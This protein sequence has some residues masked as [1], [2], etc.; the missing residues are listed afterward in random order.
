MLLK[1]FLKKKEKNILKKNKMKIE[2]YSVPEDE[3]GKL[4]KEFLM[5]NKLKFKEEPIEKFRY[6]NSKKESILM[7]KYSHS[8]HVCDGYQELFLKQLLEHIEKYNL[9]IH[10]TD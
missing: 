3:A 8:I 4:I 10:G 1:S 2:L 9:K 7:V 6:P 5:K